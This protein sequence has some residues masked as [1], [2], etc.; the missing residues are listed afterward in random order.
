MQILTPRSR[1]L[2]DQPDRHKPDHGQSVIAAIIWASWTALSRLHRLAL[3]VAL[4]GFALLTL[5]AMANPYSRFDLPIMNAV[6]RVEHEW[7]REITWAI[8]SVTGSAGAMTAWLAVTVGMAFARWWS[9]LLVTLIVPIGG[10]LNLAIERG[11]VA[12][13]RPHLPDLIRGSTSWE[14]GSYP[15]GHVLGAVML[16]GLVLIWSDRIARSWLRWSVRIWSGSL[17]AVV[18]IGRIWQGAHWPTDVMAGYLLGTALV[19][20]LAA[21]EQGLGGIRRDT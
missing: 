13:T 2:F 21:L 19:I 8:A 12:R 18:G 5:D 11:L 3:T 7:L 10:V 20:A 6:Q 16:Y 14:E 17:L 1:R 15:S 9:S 4:V